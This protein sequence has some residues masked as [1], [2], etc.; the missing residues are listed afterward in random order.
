MYGNDIQPAPSIANRLHCHRKFNLLHAQQELKSLNAEEQ[1][2]AAETSIAILWK[3]IP[4]VIYSGDRLPV[5]L[6]EP[7]IETLLG[8]KPEK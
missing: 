5:V 6:C 7:V 4:A 3:R 2:R 1:L 8:F